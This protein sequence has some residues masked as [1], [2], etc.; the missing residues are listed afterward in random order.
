MDKVPPQLR[1]RPAAR[2]VGMFLLPKRIHVEVITKKRFSWKS[3]Q[4]LLRSDIFRRIEV[5]EEE[6]QIIVSDPIKLVVGGRLECSGNGQAET[7]HQTLREGIKGVRLKAMGKV[8]A[9]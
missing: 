7:V 8:F 5:A 4:G 9:T 1:R 2:C 6:S 3:L